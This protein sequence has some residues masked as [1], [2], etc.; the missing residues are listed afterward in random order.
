VVGE[1]GRKLGRDPG[2]FLSLPQQ[3]SAGIRGDLAPFET[4]HHLA[5]EKG[6]EIERRMRT[7][8]RHRAAFLLKA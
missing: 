8:C 5:A 6:L 2:R 3:Q 1:T 4:G 7:L